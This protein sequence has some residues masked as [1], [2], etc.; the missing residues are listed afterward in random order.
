MSTLAAFPEE[1]LERI[2]AAVVVAPPTP[3]PRAPWHTRP[4]AEDA[5]RPTRGSVLLVSRAFHR[6]AL[7]LFYHTVVLHSPSQARA[8]LATLSADPL[9]ARAVRSLI[10]PA[11]STECAA[12]LALVAPQLHLLDVTLPSETEAGTA[13][14]AALQS[15]PLEQQESNLRTLAVR[16]APSTY[17]SQPAPRAVLTALASVV[18]ASPFLVR[19]NNHIL[20]PLVRPCPRAPRQRPVH[21][22]SIAHPAHVP[23]R[24]WAPPLLAIS[25]NPTLRRIC[26]ER[27]A[28]GT[29]CPMFASPV[30]PQRHASFSDECTPTRPLLS[31]GLF[32]AAAR[33]HTRLAELV[34]AGT[35]VMG[36]R[37]RASTVGGEG[38]ERE[39]KG[40]GKKMEGQPTRPTIVMTRL[41][42]SLVQHPRTYLPTH[43]SAH[44]NQTRPPLGHIPF[45]QPVYRIPAY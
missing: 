14:A 25:A 30:K 32:L 4:A 44:Q 26:L 8:L 3:H 17:L 16:K 5:Q 29:S 11:P 10:L 31:T 1:L 20:P 7:P 9:L 33:R 28:Q 40:K 12:V 2:L 19:R 37:G 38:W 13:L 36:W 15:L 35:V 39:G 18:L 24:S 42:A 41:P 22:T 27:P 45:F 6:I 21:R 43:P 23:P 34:R